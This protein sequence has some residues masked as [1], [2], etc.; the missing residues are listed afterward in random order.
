MRLGQVRN[1]SGSVYCVLIEGHSRPRSLGDV[2]VTGA[3]VRAERDG[4]GSKR[5]RGEVAGDRGKR[6]G[7]KTVHSN[8]RPTG[9]TAF[10]ATVLRWSPTMLKEGTRRAVDLPPLVKPPNHYAGAGLYPLVSQRLRHYAAGGCSPDAAGP[11]LPLL[12]P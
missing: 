8:R 5:K 10:Y 3:D 12:L 4:G 6:G 1:V 9:P 7:R 11:C 2:G